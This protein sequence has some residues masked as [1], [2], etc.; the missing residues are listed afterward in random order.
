MVVEVDEYWAEICIRLVMSI[1]EKSV[2]LGEL[3]RNPV[4]KLLLDEAWKNNL[5]LISGLTT[6]SSNI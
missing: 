2:C 4:L 6:G 3:L 1:G 5:F